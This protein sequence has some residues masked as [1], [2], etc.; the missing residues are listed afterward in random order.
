M[1][2]AQSASI[3]KQ[4]ISRFVGEEVVL[5]DVA[6]G[7]Y[8]G[9]DPVG[10]C[11]WQQIID[12]KSFAEVCDGVHNEYE[13]PYEELERDVLSLVQEL[14]ARGLLTIVE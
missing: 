11:I 13:V 6:N 9:L 1:K 5:L 3:P 8:F 14:E 2:L 4:V 7:T 10:A 12:G